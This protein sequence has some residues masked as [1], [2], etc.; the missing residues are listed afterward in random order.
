[1]AINFLWGTRGTAYALLTT[2]LNTMAS[3]SICA[4]G[5]EIDNTANGYQTGL[6]HLHI[7]SNSL[8][9]V[10]GSACNIYFMPSNAGATYPNFTS[11]AS[12]VLA[13]SNYLVG[14][15]A[16]FPAAV[17]AAAVDEWLRD[18]P[19]PDGKFKCALEYLGAGAGSW[20]GSGNTL[21][22]FP[23]PSQY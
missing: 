12:P 10:A 15:I 2:Q 20:P 21:D 14:T 18:V 11:G 13:R 6:L 16:L 5:P 1:M 4:A 3:G 7:A 8:A 17:S 23:T 9:F 22:I 19:I